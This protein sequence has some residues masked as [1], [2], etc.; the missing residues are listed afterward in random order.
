MAARRVRSTFVCNQSKSEE[1]CRLQFLSAHPQFTYVAVEGDGNCMFRSIAEFYRRTHIRI[2][3]VT[4]PENY[5]ELRRYLARRFEEYVRENI[6]VQAMLIDLDYN[7]RLDQQR[8]E[9]EERQ[10]TM[11]FLK[12]EGRRNSPISHSSPLQQV[13]EK[14]VDEILGELHETTVWNTA[15]FDAMVERVPAILNVNLDIYIVNPPSGKIKTYVVSNY[16]HTPNDGPEVETTI[17]LFLADNHY[18]LLYP[19]DAIDAAEL[20]LAMQHSLST[21]NNNTR[22]RRQEQ[23]NANAAFAA[24]LQ[25]RNNNLQGRL[26]QEQL[27]AEFA[28]NLASLDLSNIPSV[29]PKTRK[30]PVVGVLPISQPKTRKKPAV[31]VLP[32]SYNS[33]SSS[34]SNVSN[35]EAITNAEFEKEFPYG[36]QTVAA[37]RKY[38]QGRNMNIPESVKKRE[39]Y[40]LFKMIMMPTINTMAKNEKRK[41]KIA[42]RRLKR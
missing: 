4:H 37:M 7:Y 13:E 41:R 11:E 39:L 16:M 34:I 2:P 24:S 18:G 30:K 15:A 42:T 40:D 28:A 3:G 33:N 38:L 27:N 12:R 36:K 22:R 1:R 25:A 19:T 23:E 14:T 6:D 35:V 26:R 5:V 8:L 10:L 20:N 9:E 32:P 17:S 29:K 21:F 31:A